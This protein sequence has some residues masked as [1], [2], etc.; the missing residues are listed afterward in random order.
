MTE[1]QPRPVE[2]PL[3]HRE[4]SSFVC[5][6][7]QSGVRAICRNI[8]EH[9]DALT[10]EVTWEVQTADRWSILYRSMFNIH[11]SA[12]RSSLAK[13]LAEM[14]RF[15]FDWRTAINQ[16]AIVV[17]DLW[18]QGE[19]VLRLADVET[20][21]APTFL[22]ERI[23]PEDDVTVMY[24]NGEAGKSLLLMGM[25]VAIASGQPYAGRW[26]VRNPGPC[27]YLDWETNQNDQRRRFGRLSSGVPVP[28]GFDSLPIFYRRMTGSLAD[29]FDVIQTTVD[30]EGIRFVGGD[31]LG[32]A[33]GD[34]LD[35]AAA[36]IRV[37]DAARG[38]RTTFLFTAHIT[39]EATRGVAKGQPATIFGSKFFEL[40]ARMTWEVRGGPNELDDVKTIAMLNRK[41]NNVRHQEPLAF[42]VEFAPDYGPV[43]ICDVNIADQPSGPASLSHRVA[44]L[45]TKGAKTVGD[46]AQL[47]GASEE[48]VRTVLRRM[49]DK[50]DARAI[51]GTRPAKWGLSAPEFAGVQASTFAP[52]G[53]APEV[54]DGPSGGSGAATAVDVLRCAECGSEEDIR[55]TSEAIPVCPSCAPE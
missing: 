5:H 1:D 37:M 4:G 10:S 25:Q 36:A 32:F 43:T 20:D 18:R 50:G 42:R 29:N 26:A 40:S 38:L 19:P 34:D 54:D 23:L 52:A 30:R 31:S 27:L 41:S 44:Q 2:R 12:T 48:S 22:I 24:G 35:I 6:W 13:A 47:T 16:L 39:K 33:V 45:L 11:A 51:V 28:A 46:L 53:D 17:P 15:T 7:E 14:A 21:S 55:Y 8:R 9:S 3:L 49:A